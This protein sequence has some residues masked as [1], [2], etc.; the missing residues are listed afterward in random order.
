MTSS[1]VRTGYVLE[2]RGTAISPGTFDDRSFYDFAT[3]R[4]DDRST[5]VNV[6][7]RFPAEFSDMYRAELIRMMNSMQLPGRD[8]F[9]NRCG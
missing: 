3:I 2:G 8:I 4:R 9:N 6:G 1:P 7:G 5:I